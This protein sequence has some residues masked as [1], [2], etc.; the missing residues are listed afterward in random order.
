M[1]EA[2]AMRSTTGMA[3]GPGARGSFAARVLEE[4]ALAQEA[5]LER[6]RAARAAEEAARLAAP[7][8]RWRRRAPTRGNVEPRQGER[9][10][11]E[12]YTAAGEA[13]GPVEAG[14]G[15]RAL[16]FDEALAACTPEVGAERT[17]A[18]AGIA[19]PTSDVRRA[20]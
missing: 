5:A 18:A 9:R 3:A 8:R 10:Q 4:E 14:G 7:I 20:T 13:G 1:E 17:V 19:E 11:Q 16:D 2:A 6:T 15:A 12:V